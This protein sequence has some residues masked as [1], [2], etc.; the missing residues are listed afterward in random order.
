MEFFGKGN[1]GKGYLVTMTIYGI[2][3]MLIFVVTFLN[4]EEVVPPSVCLLYTSR[5]V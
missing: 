4:T 2:A 3:A 5:C 1:A